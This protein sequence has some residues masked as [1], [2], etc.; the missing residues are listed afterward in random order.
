MR[1]I[2]MVLVAVLLI[3][4]PQTEAARAQHDYTTATNFLCDN[5]S[6]SLPTT[7]VND[8]FCDCVDGSDEPGTA[9]CSGIQ[10]T[11]PTQSTPSVST[12]KTKEEEDARTDSPGFVCRG[13][14]RATTLPASRVHDGICDC[15]DGSDEAPFA[16]PDSCAEM[17]KEVLGALAAERTALVAGMKLKKSIVEAGTK[18]R[19]EWVESYVQAE[20]SA[21]ALEVALGVSHKGVRAPTKEA[22]DADVGSDIAKRWGAKTDTGFADAEKELERKVQDRLVSMPP[23]RT[24]IPTLEEDGTIVVAAADGMSSPQR[25]P[26]P[27]VKPA[28]VKPDD[29]D[30]A[31][32]GV[33]QQPATTEEEGEED[34]AYAGHL[35]TINNAKKQVAEFRKVRTYSSRHRQCQQLDY[36]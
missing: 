32:M 21:R 33:W 29:W 35:A 16:C 9:A 15:C 24:P 12:D 13:G 6:R 30:E 25:L 27:A 18:L 26:K 20:S 4:T 22:G 11:A 19:A 14:V 1:G 5:G 8:D 17:H 28:V 31:T 23:P 7:S 34:K 36:T 3:C 2:L 10:P